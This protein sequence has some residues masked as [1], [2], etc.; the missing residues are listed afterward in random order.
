MRARFSFATLLTR[1][2]EHI[3]AL[4]LA[5]VISIASGAPQLYVIHQM[6]PAYRGIFPSTSD[7]NRYYEAR[8]EEV[9]EGYPTLGNP[10]IYELRNAPAVYFW[11]PDAI[12]SYTGEAMRLD[13]QHAFAV[14]NFLLPPIL[15]LVT[16]ALLLCATQKKWLSL[17]GATLFH[18]GFFL[19]AF[20]R[21]PSPQLN[22]LFVE[23]ALLSVLLIMR[24]V[25]YAYLALGAFLGILFYIYPFYWTFTYGSVGVLFL[26]TFLRKEL[27][28]FSLS[29]FLA[30]AVGVIIGSQNLIQ[31]FLAAQTQAYQDTIWRLGLISSHTPAGF[32]SILLCG[33]VFVA[34]ALLLAIK[35]IPRNDTPSWFFL[36][37]VLGGILAANSQIVTGKNLEFS[38]HYFLP[39]AYVAFLGAAYL[40]AIFSERLQKYSWN[41]KVTYLAVGLVVIVLVY[42]GTSS[43]LHRSQLNE[44]DIADQ[45]YGPL[46][47][48]LKGNTAPESVVMASEPT[49]HLIAA[50]T[51]NRVFYSRNA[52]LHLMTNNEAWTRLLLMNWDTSLDDSFLL[53][54]EGQIWST[55]YLNENGREA[56]LNK[57]R[58]LLGL[59]QTQLERIPNTAKQEFRAFAAKL[60]KKPPQ[61]VLGDR[62]I[63]YVI[64]EPDFSIPQWVKKAYPHMRI[65]YKEGDFTVY[66]LQ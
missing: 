14:F 30:M 60:E 37:I 59:P 10:Y 57:L 8:A 48:W 50:Y 12:L 1:L 43:V 51:P 62:R 61:E 29:L 20:I 55:H 40:V 53:A 6:G 41:G 23:L 49:S 5:C 64:S 7:D 66:V 25:K 33:L 22:F 15:F 18:L 32:V 36:S 11:L 58:K 42:G 44:S 65:V 9:R 34:Y 56:Q 27:R 19:D 13:V 45:A 28:R 38:S 21:S 26:S 3:P 31:T 24:N 16:Y 35:A 46:M 54:H 52:N 63:D 17:L 47:T 2:R 4:L 39:C